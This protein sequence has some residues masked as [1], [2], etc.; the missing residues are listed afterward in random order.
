M[1]T[2]LYYYDYY[3]PYILDKKER[4]FNTSFQNKDKKYFMNKSLNDN[5]KSYIFEVSHNFN[6]LKSVSN[7]LKEKLNTK[8]MTEG[9]KEDIENDIEN[10]AQTYNRFI[11]FLDENSENSKKFKN[12]SSNIKN[13]L[14]N[15]TQVLNK[16]GINISEDFYLSV[17]EN[18]NL[19]SIQRDKENLNKFYTKI[20][21]TLCKFMQEPMSKHM[22]FKEF[23]FYFN[24][25][26]G[27][28]KDK[29]FRLIEQGILF[30]YML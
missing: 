30:D 10:F 28:D 21:N 27:Y 29:S 20:Y 24:Y 5:V 12:M 11:G 1:L 26:C 17:K 14:K 19:K 3:K 23:S 4:S 18:N 15:N 16:M 7:N 6:G 8:Y 13:F 2:N 22:G 25:S 9:I